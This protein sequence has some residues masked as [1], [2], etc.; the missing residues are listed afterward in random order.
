MGFDQTEFGYIPSLAL[1]DKPPVNTGIL[2]HKWIQYRPI[3]QISNTGLLEFT[4]PGTSTS[5]INLACSFL[6]IQG[7]IIKGNG[8]EISKTDDVAFINLPLQ[9]FWRQI[10]ISLQQNIISHRVGTNY[11]YKAYLDTLLNVS[12]KK[13]INQLSSQIFNKDSFGYMDKFGVE[14]P[15]HFVRWERT[16]GGQIVQLSA[17][18]CL[19]IGEQ[20]RFILN[21]VEINLKFWPNKPSFYLMTPDKESRYEFMITDAYFNAC[22]IEVS[23]AVIVGH[24]AALKDYPALYPFNQSDVKTFSIA[25]GLYDFTVDNIFQGD[26]PTSVIVGLVPSEA[27]NGSYGRNPFNFDHFNCNFCGFYINGESIPNEPF[28]P[29]YPE[30]IEKKKGVT[31]PETGEEVKYKEAYSY[32][33]AYLSLFG[34]M[35]SS[36]ENIA[37]SWEE[38]PHGFCLYKFNFI[39]KMNNG[40]DSGYISSLPRRGHTRLSFKFKKALEESVNVIIYARFPRILQIDEA[41]N[42]TF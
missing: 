15:A 9:T 30:K 16:Q 24:A 25:K 37:I 34:E 12:E 38:Y 17:P 27:Y 32:T 20:D 11:A 10:D 6:Q 28:Q 4:I 13:Q 23:P 21:G 1:F 14:N 39:E 19:D 31:D 3:S 36:D 7:K 2:S 40:E 29:N 5:Y 41:R 22:M 26:V 33:E 35:Y 18:L 42:V 8:E